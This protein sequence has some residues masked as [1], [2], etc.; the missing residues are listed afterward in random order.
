MTTK[1][2]KGFAKDEAPDLGSMVLQFS[3]L[4]LKGGFEIKCSCVLLQVK[5]NH[6]FAELVSKPLEMMYLVA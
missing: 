3:L 6:T 1:V 5:I 4:Q 2:E